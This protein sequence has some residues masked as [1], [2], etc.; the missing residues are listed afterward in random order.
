MKIVNFDPR[1]AIKSS[2]LTEFDE[3]SD[4]VGVIFLSQVDQRSLGFELPLLAS[5]A[6]WAANLRAGQR[7]SLYS[8]EIIDTKV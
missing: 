2:Y 1:N 5:T 3:E 7:A 6:L 8:V 4:G